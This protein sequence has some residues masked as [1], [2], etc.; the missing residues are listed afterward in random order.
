[1]SKSNYHKLISDQTKNLPDEVLSEILD[2]VEFVKVKKVKTKGFD[3]IEAELQFLNR[4][5]SEHLESEFLNYK[6]IYPVEK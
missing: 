1:M 4:L 2:F 3:N 6:E 5:E